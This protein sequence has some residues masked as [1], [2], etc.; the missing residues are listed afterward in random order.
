M[1]WRSH[2]GALDEPHGNEKSGAAREGVVLARPCMAASINV[3]WQLGDLGCLNQG[4]ALAWFWGKL[5][6]LSELPNAPCTRKRPKGPASETV[7]RN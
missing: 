1:G 4:I 5:L 7:Q 2:S 6:V 3:G